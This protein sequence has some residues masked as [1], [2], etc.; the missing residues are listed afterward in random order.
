MGR[1]SG[2]TTGLGAWGCEKVMISVVTITF[3]NADELWVTLASLAL[4]KNVESVVVNGGAPISDLGAAP[5]QPRVVIEEK[6]HGISDAFNKGWRAS[7]GA[8]VAYLNSG[9]RLLDTS[10]YA[11]AEAVLQSDPSIGFVYADLRFLDRATGAFRMVPRGRGFED[12]GKGMPFPHPT[13][14]V[15]REIFDKIG[16]FSESYRIAM[17]FEFAVRLLKAGYR[18]HYLPGEVVEMDG[19][20]VSSIR[21]G[22]G[23]EECRKA[24]NTHGCFEGRIKRDYMMRVLRHRIRRFLRTVF[25]DALLAALKRI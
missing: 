23:I 21:E 22:A 17:D 11:R 15:R 9:D 24:L 7:H 10:Y 4:A 16:G 8:A 25:G 6:D 18:G 5:F 3:N 20:G 13:M 12:L 1:L 14:V 2:Q 19:G